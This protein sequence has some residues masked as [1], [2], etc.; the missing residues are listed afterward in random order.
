MVTAPRLDYLVETDMVELASL[1]F[2]DLVDCRD[3]LTI[4]APPAVLLALYSSDV[5][6][7]LI[8]RFNLSLALVLPILHRQP[9]RQGRGLL[10]G[11]A[12]PA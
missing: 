12:T 4:V 7:N 9:P 6:L 5:V 2:V 11:R 3:E 1:L 8:H 10:Q